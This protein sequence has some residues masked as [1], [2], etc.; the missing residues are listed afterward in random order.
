MAGKRLSGIIRISPM[1][2]TITELSMKGRNPNCPDDGCQLDEKSSWPILPA[3]SIG[4][5]F[6]S[7]PRTMSSGNSNTTNTQNIVQL[8][9]PYS[10]NRLAAIMLVHFL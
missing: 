4:E 5:A 3:L 2:V 9:A 8:P 10:F 6:T 1:A 7:N